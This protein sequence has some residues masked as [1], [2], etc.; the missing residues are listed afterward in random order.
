MSPDRGRVTG[1]TAHEVPSHGFDDAAAVEPSHAAAAASSSPQE[2]TMLKGNAGTAVGTLLRL[3]LGFGCDPVAGA[4]I[5]A[6]RA[7]PA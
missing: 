6:E 4:K 2:V 1:V 5:L 7:K 3:R